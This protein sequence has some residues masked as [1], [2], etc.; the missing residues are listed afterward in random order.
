MTAAILLGL[1]RTGAAKFSFLLSIPIITAAGLY[2]SLDLLS[3]GQAV[4]WL[5]IALGTVVSGI[6]AW[7]CI[8]VFMKLIERVGLMPFVWYR[9]A[10]GLV[11]IVVL[12]SR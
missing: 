4:D 11:L 9:L 3:Q 8:A 5:S 2:A 1:S 10:L 6:S 12:L 7:L